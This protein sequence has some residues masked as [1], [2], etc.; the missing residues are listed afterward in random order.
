MFSPELQSAADKYFRSLEVSQ[1]LIALHPRTA[2]GSGNHAALA[3]AVTLSVIAAFEGFV[4][5]FLATVLLLRGHGFA[6]VAKKITI[7]NPTV[8]LFASKIS[9]EL[10]S[11]ATRVGDGFSLRV[12]NIPGVNGRPATETV[13]WD[14]AVS[15]ADGWMEV[16][17][18]L[19]HGLASGWRSE[20]WPGPIKNVSSTPAS[21][22]LRAKPG[23]RHSIGL[24]GAIS[25]A[26]LYFYGARH[27]ATLVAEEMGETI[28]WAKAPEYPLT[29]Q[30][31]P[32]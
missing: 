26:R 12:W 25:C 8:R 16:R 5:E 23:G 10:P 15:R 7:N 1:R 14:Q 27:I 20:V 19:T 9:A 30:S 13:S 6:Q 17:H 18:C 2:G 29:K 22:V 21:S 28:D 4:E 3:P 11:I 32:E 24:T 31:V